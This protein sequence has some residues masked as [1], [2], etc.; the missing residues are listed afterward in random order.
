[1]LGLLDLRS[2]EIQEDECDIGKLGHWTWSA[3]PCAGFQ[4]L[5]D[6]A[7]NLADGS[8]AGIFAANRIRGYDFPCF[9]ILSLLSVKACEMH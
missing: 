7:V 8:L 9:A 3:K 1:M 4:C 2:N 6:V 5:A